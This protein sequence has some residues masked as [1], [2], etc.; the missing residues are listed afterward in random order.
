MFL[1]TSVNAG[2]IQLKESV[3][4]AEVPYHHQ[5]GKSWWGVCLVVMFTALF[6]C[7]A[8]SW[9]YTE[10]LGG[11]G[12]SHKQLLCLLPWHPGILAET[13]PL[14]PWTLTLSHE[15]PA[16]WLLPGLCV[17]RGRMLITTVTAAWFFYPPTPH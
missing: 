5:G 9:G 1:L 11:V 2:L 12:H 4:N 17:G 10:P 6:C 13:Q 16:P 15:T 7:R 3:Q 14:L 8:Q